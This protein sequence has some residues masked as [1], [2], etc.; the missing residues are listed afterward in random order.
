MSETAKTIDPRRK[1]TKPELRKLGTIADV[2]GAQ[3]AGTQAGG[4]KS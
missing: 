1:W 3:S 4:V 2:A